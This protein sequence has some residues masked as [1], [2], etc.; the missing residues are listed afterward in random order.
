VSNVL[1]SSAVDAKGLGG[2]RTTKPRLHEP[3]LEVLKQHRPHRQLDGLIRF[4]QVEEDTL[5]RRRDRGWSI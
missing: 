3:L 4:K 2:D 5:S 1:N